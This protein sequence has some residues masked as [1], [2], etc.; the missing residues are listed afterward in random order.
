MKKYNGII[1]DLDGTLYEKKGLGFRLIIKSPLNI[2]KIHTARKVMRE[3]SGKFFGNAEGFKSAYYKTYSELLGISENQAYN[4]EH[5]TFYKN[6]IS[7]LKKYQCR[8]GIEKLLLK[9]DK[10]CVLLSDYDR[11]DDRLQALKINLELFYLRLYSGDIGG[12]KPSPDVFLG[13]AQKM[14]CLPKEILVI[15]DDELKDGAGARA[16][17]MDFFLVNK[18][19]WPL[20]LKKFTGEN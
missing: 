20:L 14:G 18:D 19:S 13:V 6:F 11:I 15:G 7:V 16:A 10:P 3:L 9:I 12:L 5:K 1:F 8:P 17:G 2:Y 4:W